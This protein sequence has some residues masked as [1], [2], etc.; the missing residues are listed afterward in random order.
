MKLTCVTAVY[1]AIASGNRERL[2][3][4]VESVEKIG[5]EHE[6]LIYD[7]G[8]NDG[9]VELLQEL[10]SRVVGMKWRSEPDT[11]IYNALNKGVRDAQGEWFYVLGCDDYMGAPDQLVRV[12]ERGWTK[13][14]VIVSRVKKDVVG[15]VRDIGLCRRNLYFGTPYCHQG[16]LAR[17]SL[18]RQLKGFDEQY[19]VSGDYD[20]MLRY[21]LRNTRVA[22]VPERFAIY[23]AGGLSERGGRGWGGESMEIAKHHFRLSG[24]QVD[25]LKCRTYLPLR[26]TLPRLFHHDSAVRIASA[27]MIARWMLWQL[28]IKRTGI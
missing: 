24:G 4:C 5:V 14:D 18:M 2:I 17:T 26:V 20:L 3:R 23:S 22:Y 9:T 15:A 16:V 1:N 19:R 13:V 27:Y 6:H 8:S 10:G 11:G 25:L 21:H 7:G 12:L 28:G